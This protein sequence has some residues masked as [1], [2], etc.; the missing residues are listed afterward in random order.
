[1]GACNLSSQE[2]EKLHN[3]VCNELK[4]I[5]YI[6]EAKKSDDEKPGSNGFE[7]TEIE[8]S[9]Q[10]EIDRV[11][12]VVNNRK[13]KEMPVLVKAK[14]SLE[15]GSFSN[16]CTVCGCFIDFARLSFVPHTKVCKKCSK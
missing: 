13:A 2:L 14:Q 8:L 7:E 5:N 11:S 15:N 3:I 10:R 12:E 6:L 4:E 16:I 1:M 9:Q